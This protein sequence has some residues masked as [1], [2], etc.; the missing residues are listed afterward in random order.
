M[1]GISGPLDLRGLFEKREG[2]ETL[3]LSMEGMMEPLK[4]LESV[5]VPNKKYFISFEA[6]LASATHITGFEIRKPD[7]TYGKIPMQI[8]PDFRITM[9]AVQEKF[10]INQRDA[11]S[12]LAELG[13]S[14]LEHQFNGELRRV[15]KSR[16]QD[17]YSGTKRLELKRYF[18][19][20]SQFFP[21]ESEGEARKQVMMYGN[22]ERIIAPITEFGEFFA[23]S[24]S[25]MA[26][27]VLSL[28]LV[29]WEEIPTDYKMFFSDINDRFDRHTRLFYNST[30]SQGSGSQVGVQV[31][32]QLPN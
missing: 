13:L 3:V 1:S 27:I 19:A 22:A 8:V 10:G 21:R 4:D 32:V 18:G 7:S 20:T 5:G 17:F 25:D 11:Y 9:K 24:S 23:I 29:R 26:H 15:V 30:I 16:K 6:T 31:G 28:A 2:Y 12:A 14:I